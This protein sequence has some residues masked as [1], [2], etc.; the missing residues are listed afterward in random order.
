MGISVEKRKSKGGLHGKLLSRIWDP[1]ILCW[2]LASTLRDPLCALGFR[3]TF[4]GEYFY[5]YMVWIVGSLISG[6]HVHD[7]FQ[8]NSAVA[9]VLDDMYGSL[10]CAVL[11]S[12][13]C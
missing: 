9:H 2:T 10:S 13:D 8:M 11:G 12:K 5:M 4:T 1:S 3:F 6:S 7:L